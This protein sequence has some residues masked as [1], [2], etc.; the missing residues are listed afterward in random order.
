MEIM[1]T[2]IILLILVASS[3][4]ANEDYKHGI[5]GFHSESELRE[6]YQKVRESILE[7]DYEKIASL[8]HFPMSV[9]VGD[10]PTKN[11]S[12]AQFV[13]NGPQIINKKILQAVYCS[14]FDSLRSNYRGVMIGQGSIWINKIKN[15]DSDP[16]RTVIW[17]FN[18]KPT[19]V[20]ENYKN[21]YE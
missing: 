20:I 19:K 8:T 1:R 17:R 12:Q 21:C 10:V 14:T 5:A 6:F 7:K 18:N 4:I 16:W 3:A 9:Y 11:I 15:K 2:F 13:L